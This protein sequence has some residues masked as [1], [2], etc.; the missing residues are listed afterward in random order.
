[1]TMDIAQASTAM[2]QA[3]VQQQAGMSTLKA[4]LENEEAKAQGLNDMLTD[5]SEMSNQVAQ[6]PAVG[7]TVNVLA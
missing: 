2:Q 3:Q 5:V 7:Q 6:D 1:M 4:G